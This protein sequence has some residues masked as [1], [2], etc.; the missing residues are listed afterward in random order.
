MLLPCEL[1][2]VVG[3]GGLSMDDNI[4]DFTHCLV[5]LFITGLP[6]TVDPPTMQNIN[7]VKYAAFY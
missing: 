1:E 2:R 5:I 3:G 7:L 6:H 4:I